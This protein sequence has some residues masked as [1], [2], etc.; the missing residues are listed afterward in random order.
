MWGILSNWG[1][2]D[3]LDDPAAYIKLSAVFQVKNVK[4]PVLL[5]VG[6]TDGEFLLSAIEMYQALRFA[7]KDVTFLRYPE[8]GTVF[9][10]AALRDLWRREIA[11]KRVVWGKRGAVR[12]DLGGRRIIK[13]KKK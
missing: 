1:G 9:E 11:R 13:K 8:Q 4:T 5:A 7:D 2:V 6:D 3:P 12:V 10:G